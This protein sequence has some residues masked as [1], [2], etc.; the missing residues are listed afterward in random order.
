MKYVW[1]DSKGI[2]P[3]TFSKNHDD[4]LIAVNTESA[5]KI[6]EKNSLKFEFAPEA[7]TKLNEAIAA[8]QKQLEITSD[9]EYAWFQLG[10]A[11]WKK[12]NLD[13]AAN[14]YDKG[15]NVNPNN[16]RHFS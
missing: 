3:L 4:I 16:I 5:I 9:H 2:F 11:F 6:W 12:G 7:I 13:D 14:A 8:Y 15:L 1:K 10:A